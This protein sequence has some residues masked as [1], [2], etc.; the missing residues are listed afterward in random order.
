MRVLKKIEMLVGDEKCKVVVISVEDKNELD[1]E[2][3][4]GFNREWKQVREESLS[5]GNPEEQGIEA[6]QMTVFEVTA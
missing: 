1:K 4:K 3:I 2:E 6:A 5:N